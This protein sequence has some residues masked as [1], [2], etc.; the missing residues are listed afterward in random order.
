[1]K[2]TERI[3]EDG[4]SRMDVRR[5]PEERDGR[6][7]SLKTLFLVRHAKSSWKDPG[8]PDLLRPLNKRG[9]RDAP[10]MGRR[11]ARRGFEVELILSSPA[12]RAQ[13]TAEALAEELLYPWDEI[14]TEEDLYEADAEEIL[15][16]IKKQDE[17]IDSLM[18][19][20]HNPGMT[21]LANYLGRADFE[22]VPT[23]GVL[24][25]RYDIETWSDIDAMEPTTVSFDCPKGQPL[26][27]M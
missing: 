1:L 5:R 10:M 26:E 22:N 16:V 15:A 9:R 14:V 8:L 20:G 2:D 21:S 23:T 24:Q 17:W 11:L 12:T 4:S 25:L 7:Y 3:V 27:G 18:V 13:Q 19:V 6:S